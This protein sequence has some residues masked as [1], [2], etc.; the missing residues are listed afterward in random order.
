MK[1][2]GLESATLEFKREKPTKQQIVNT[3]IGFCNFCGGR[4]VIG[5]ADDGTVIGIDEELA[6]EMRESLHRSIIN[7][8]TPIIIPSI[9]LQRLGEKTVLVI[10]VSSGMTKPYFRTDEGL[11]HGTY[12]R[13]GPETVKATGELVRELQWEAQGHFLDEMPLHRASIEDLDIELFKKYLIE[14]GYIVEGVHFNELLI[15][16]GLVTEEHRHSYPSVGGILL[17]GKR[18]QQLLPEAYIICSQFRGIG[19]RDV[20]ASQDCTGTL[21]QQLNQT[22]SF[23][24]SRL[25]KEYTIRDLQ[26]SEQLE[27]PLLALREA[28]INAVLHRN[29][30]IAGPSKIAIFEDRLEIYSPGNFPR[31]I[32]TNQL[33]CGISVARNRVVSQFFRQA[34]LIERIGSGWTTI[35]SAYRQWGLPPPSVI[36]GTGFVKVVF[37]RPSPKVGG[38]SYKETESAHPFKEVL[39]LMKRNGQLSAKELMRHL[40]IS[41]QTASRL[42]S[43]LLKEN[44][45]T[46]VGRGKATHYLLRDNS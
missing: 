27:V 43:R 30:L 22:F 7:S 14:R 41:R 10:E 3:V 21:F 18:P 28:I 15:Q 2:D 6:V 1:F 9:Y 11:V 13:L 16:Y 44:M 40:Q 25:N 4:I 12:L 19:G 29:Y 20:I 8:C 42:L 31:P 5:V 34:K 46:R 39:L 45:I 17:F 24:E 37:P 38:S 32:P 36:E 26:R 23:V 33:E 35:F